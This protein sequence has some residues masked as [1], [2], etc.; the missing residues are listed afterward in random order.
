MACFLL[1]RIFRD[2]LDA[3]E[4]SRVRFLDHVV[5][6]GGT[7]SRGLLSDEPGSLG[8]VFALRGPME[9]MGPELSATSPLNLHKPRSLSPGSS[10]SGLGRKGVRTARPR[11]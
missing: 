2:E 5:S 3:N 6:R 4:F 8:K 1:L 11:W 9:N 7:T 10:N